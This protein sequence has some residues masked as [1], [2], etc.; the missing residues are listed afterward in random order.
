MFYYE[1]SIPSIGWRK[2]FFLQK[3]Q[4]SLCVLRPSISKKNILWEN[5]KI[6]GIRNESYSAFAID[7]SIGQLKL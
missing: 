5:D 1:D 6:S 2:G 3:K 7:D 4:S